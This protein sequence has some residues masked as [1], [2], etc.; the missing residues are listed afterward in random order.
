MPSD[1]IVYACIAAGI[2]GGL[3]AGVFQSFSDFVMRS[4]IAVGPA[5][6]IESMQMINR[7]V[8][9][10]FFLVI[11]LG[12]APG[13]LALV[14][15]AHLY[16][17]GAAQMWIFAGASIYLVGVFLVTMLGNVPMNKHLDHLDPI[18]AQAAEY[19]KYY[20]VAWTR[21][22]HIRT[23]GSLAAAVCFLF[24]SITLA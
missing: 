12:L 18:T 21:W 3:V 20:G 1:W 14:T 4:L 16:L 11:L 23:L 7:K 6:G 17:A 15:Y 5:G 10:S 13:S 2:G 9:R 8:Y 19:W 22:N 24:A